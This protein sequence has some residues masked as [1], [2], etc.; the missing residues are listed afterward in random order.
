MAPDAHVHTKVRWPGRLVEA[1]ERRA[2]TFDDSPRNRAIVAAVY[3]LIAMAVVIPVV[4]GG[5]QAMSRIDEPTHADWAYQIAHFRIPAQGSEIAPEIR[6]IWAC[7][8]QERYSLPDCGTSVPAWRFPYKGQ[9]YN[10]S[11][12]PLYYAIVGIPAR[13]VAA[14]TPLNFV[15]AAR[16]SGIG[17]LAS[18]M[19]MLF[20]ALRR[21]RVDPAVSIVAPLL[22]I[23]FPR[24]LHASTTVN[25]D[26]VSTLAGAVALWLA[27]RLF[28]EKSE[29]WVLPAV[30]AGLMGLTKY[31][32]TI[33]FIAL[34]VLVIA[35]ALRDRGLRRL[36]RADVLFPAVMALA[37][38]VPYL[39]WQTFQAS[40]GDPNWLNPLVGLNTRDVVGLPGSEWIG[41]LFLG[42]NLASDYYIQPPLD[43]ALLVTWTRLLNVLVIGAMFAIVVAF[44]KE[45]ARRSL[46]WLL[47]VGA[48]LY[49][50]AVQIQA[51]GN[52][53]VPQ[54]FPNPTGRYGMAL[55]PGA[56]ACMVMAATKAGF[57]RSIYAMTIAGL[58]VVSVVITVGLQRMPS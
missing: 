15:E 22:L 32:T 37:I 38:I 54:Y 50:L 5:G 27:A 39:A 14:V 33:P 12:P 44:V 28:L 34:A 35:R 21:W 52:T 6:D 18:G 29:D 1:L 46:G 31:I 23:S 9:N 36:T 2:S 25:P 57:R 19:F 7:M 51:Y 49:P 11:H 16:L 4:F 8:G 58:V 13:A 26:A 30:L 47:G 24:V 40:R 56:I 3:T 48:V 55:V 43:I 53:A 10:F 17:W 41:T 20:V 42:F 45:P